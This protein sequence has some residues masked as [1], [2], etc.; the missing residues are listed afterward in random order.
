[1]SCGKY[2][3]QCQSDFM[4][5]LSAQGGEAV[6][7]WPSE[8]GG[9]VLE[10]SKAAIKEAWHP[11]EGIKVAGKVPNSYCCTGPRRLGAADDAE[12]YVLHGE[13]AVRVHAALYPAGSSRHDDVAW[14]LLCSDGITLGNS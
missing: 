1:M 12:G 2:V 13:V 11:G 5:N 4:M 14:H 3:L 10:D 9:M 6:E 7:R 8:D